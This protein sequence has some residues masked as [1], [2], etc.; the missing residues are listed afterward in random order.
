MLRLR[1][2]AADS[3]HR[4]PPT[5][6]S[7]VNR[8]KGHFAVNALGISVLVTYGITYYAVGTAAPMIARGFGVGTDW[9]FGVFSA[10]LFLNAGVASAAGRLVDRIGGGRALFLGSLGRAGAVAALTFAPEFWTFAAALMAVML[11]SQ[12]TEYDAAFAAAVQTQGEH[13]RR[14]MSQITLWGGFASTAFWPLSAALLD[15]I[16]WRGMFQIYAA[17]MVLV[18]LPLGWLF[19]WSGAQSK[20]PAPSACGAAAAPAAG[21]A[22]LSAREEAQAFWLL[23]AAFCLL[24][25]AMALPV[26]FLPVLQGLGFGA[27][28]LVA[29]TVFGPSQT[30]ARALEFIVLRPWPPTIMTAVVFALLYGAGNGI[31]YVNRGTV[32]LALFGAANYGTRLGRLAT[33]RLIVSASMPLVMALVMERIGVPAAVFMCAC[34]GLL[35]TACFALLAR[36]YAQ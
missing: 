25:V 12:L 21:A 24:A 22:M 28:A 18:A 27:A 9:I 26:I 36:R 5:E 13:A 2:A 6:T 31:S 34:A 19:G 17:L 35:A 10:A 14:S 32:T 20:Q 16:G 23:T 30:G 1:T 7:T 4:A 3:C 11:F 8:S 29:G 33:Y 15:E